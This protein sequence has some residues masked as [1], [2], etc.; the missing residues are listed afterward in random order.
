[1]ARKKRIEAMASGKHKNRLPS[2]PVLGVVRKVEF[3][4]ESHRT[5]CPTW[6]PARVAGKDLRAQTQL[7]WESGSARAFG[8]L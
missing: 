3:N 5:Q 7:L 4:S 2:D 6:R 8:L 1:M